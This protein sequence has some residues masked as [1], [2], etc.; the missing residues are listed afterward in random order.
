IA[1]LQH[2]NVV[3][4]YEAGELDGCPYITMEYVEGGNLQKRIAGVPQPVHAAAQLIQVLAETVDFAHQRGIAHRD[5]KP[6][7]VLL[8]PPPAHSTYPLCHQLYGTPKIADFGLAKR[9]QEDTGQ[10]KTGAILGTP[11]YMAPEQAVGKSKDVGIAA[12][13]YA[14]GAI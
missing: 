7:N 12:D 1:H 14:L 11:S 8:A 4:V 6:A 2:P 10:T 13:Q 5:L 3:Q 9:L